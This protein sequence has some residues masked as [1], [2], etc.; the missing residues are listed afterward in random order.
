MKTSYK[1][2]PVKVWCI[3]SKLQTKTIQC[4][5]K[6][7]QN[8]RKRQCWSG[9][10]IINFEYIFIRLMWLFILYSVPLTNLMPLVSFYPPENLW[11]SGVFR[12]IEK[13]PVA[14]NRLTGI[15]K[16]KKSF[17]KLHITYICSLVLVKNFYYNKSLNKIFIFTLL[18][19]GSIN[20]MKHF[21]WC[22][23]SFFAVNYFQRK[24]SVIEVFLTL[25]KHCK[26]V[27]KTVLEPTQLT[28]ICSKSTIETLEKGVK[29]V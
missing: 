17:M 26:V 29:Y 27:W 10:F 3:F 14:L 24:P 12:L 16:H 11:C 4:S 6:F 18:H 13:K 2:F 15:R 9:A 23:F 5:N 1:A 28:F 25:L 22:I 19:F 20:V 21:L 8:Q 7:I